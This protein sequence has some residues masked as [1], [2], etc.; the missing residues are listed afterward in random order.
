MADLCGNADMSICPSAP[1]LM[2]GLAWD[3]EWPSEL[4]GSEHDYTHV[5]N[6]SAPFILVDG[7]Q[8]S[9][10]RGRGR[11]KGSMKAKDKDIRLTEKGGCSKK[12]RTGNQG[13]N[14]LNE[15]AESAP[16]V[17]R[18]RGSGYQQRAAAEALA[19]GETPAEVVKNPIGRPCKVVN[20]VSEMTPAN[21][22]SCY[23]INSLVSSSIHITH[24]LL[25]ST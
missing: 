8:R 6:Q 15:M 24:V 2:P 12:K 17:G 11:L 9:K 19:W 22:V 4:I 7:N 21:S 25:I 23:H 5:P 14:D 13:S 16:T 10:K 20:F 1:A 3:S 18:P